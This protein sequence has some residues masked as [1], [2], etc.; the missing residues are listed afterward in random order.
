MVP[1]DTYM[2][3]DGV[4]DE[5]LTFA[6]FYLEKKIER[7]ICIADDRGKIYYPDMFRTTRH[8]EDEFFHIPKPITEK[9]YD[10]QKKNKTLYYRIK[11]NDSHVFVIVQ[12]IPE[13]L[14]YKTLS[15]L[16]EAKLAIKCY[17]AKINKNKEAFEKKLV[18]YLF[19]KSN[20][21]IEDIISLSEREQNLDKPYLVLLM[22]EKTGQEIDWQLICS[23]SY[24]Y[25]RRRMLDVISIHWERYLLVLLPVCSENDFPRIGE[26]ASD[27]K[28][29]VGFKDSIE[30]NFNIVFS[31]GIGQ[32]YPL[33]KLYNGFYEARVALTI[34]GFMGKEEFIQYFSD[35]GI[36]SFIFSQSPEKIKSYCLKTL[37]RLIKHDNDC[38]L[39]STVRTLLDS[40]FS[41]KST[42][43]R[44]HIHVNTL[45]Y[46]INKIERLL[47]ID[48]YKMNNQVDLYIAIK[49]WDTFNAIQYSPT[50]FQD[51]FRKA[52]VR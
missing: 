30:K 42:A 40:G 33:V 52:Q 27:I 16:K 36:Y 4:L 24:E 49:V 14:L 39:L 22:E 43:D 21:S 32:T 18:E 17:F 2:L 45:Y 8:I 5:G 12:N 28:E 9:D 48:L 23:Y 25:F 41:M 35:L 6:A 19:L 37:G 44:L 34:P 26:E 1:R 51:N 46:R 13:N 15:V 10:Y 29:I 20:T 47:D 38:T 31:L 11:Y 3:I 50:S 7:P